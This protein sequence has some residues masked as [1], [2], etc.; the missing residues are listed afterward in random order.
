VLTEKIIIKGLRQNNLKNINIEI[1]KG[2]IVV[3]TGVSGSGKSSIV[4]DTVAAEATRQMNDTYPAFVRSRLPKFASPDCDSIENLSPSVVID[5]TPLGST[6]RSTVGTSSEIYSAL[7]LLFSRIGQPYAGSASF[8]SFNDPNGMCRE[9]SGLGMVTDVDLDAIMNK[10]LSLRSGALLDSTVREG[11]W[12]WKQYISSGLFDADKRLRDYSEKEM[13]LLLHGGVR[14]DGKNLVGLLDIYRKRYLTRDSASINAEKAKRVLKQKLC[15]CCNGKRLNRIALS[16]WINGNSIADL[17]DMELTDLRLEL[18]KINEPCVKELVQTTIRSIDRMIDIG[19]G[20]LSLSRATATLSGGEAQRVKLVRHLGSSL[21]DMLYIFDEPSTGMH[22]RDVYRMNNLLKELRDKGN[23]VL[24]VEHDEDVIAIADEIIDIGPLAGKGGGT[25][26]YQGT[27]EGLERA[28]TLTGRAISSRKAISTVTTRPSRFLSVENAT[29]H[30]LKNASV[31]I[32]LGCICTV[33]GVAGSGKSS[34]MQVFADKYSDRVIKIDQKP[35]FATNRSMPCSYLGFFDEVRKELARENNVDEGMFSFNS[36]GACP[37]C[38]GKGET[39]TELAFM[40]PIVTVCEYC[41][42]QRYSDEALSYKYKGKNIVEIL[43][44]TARE[45]EDFF[46]NKRIKAKIHSMNEVG[47][48]YLTLGQP[49]STLSGGERQR[50]KLSASIG[51]RGSIFLLDEPTTGL[52]PT[53]IDK[54]MSLFST[55]VKKGCSVVL[56]E[57]NLEVMKMSDYIIDVGPDGGKNGGEVVFCGTPLEM[58]AADTITARCLKK[59]NDGEAFTEAELKEMVSVKSNKQEENIMGGY[60]IIPIGRVESDYGV[61]RI[62]L[63][64]KYRDALTEL[65][66]FSH[67]QVLCWFEGCDNESAR[68]HLINIK[69]YTNGPDKVGTFATRS[70]ERPN[71]IALS[72]CEIASVDKENAIINLTYIDAFT[73][74][75]VCDIKPYTPSADK[76]ENAKVPAWCAHWPKSYEESESFD[77]EKEFNF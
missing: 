41:N 73:G 67:I 77:W 2:I 39:V 11:S 31:D 16:C 40:D 26:V 49:M 17:C 22:P 52:H 38:S 42:G 34:L 44:L 32:P 27:Y 71:P 75:P 36:S 29:L 65:Q 7:R 12:Y 47:L 61:F 33:T 58:L 35:I 57:H 14:A 51:K 62:V 43:S 76:V 8:F 25:V 1:P 54:L 10:E 19:L 28:D 18:E 46:D 55:L 24:V 3:F 20:Y 13:N 37:H 69:P 9:C 4:F 30:N 60:K 72:V 48:S 68:N 23:T 74:T 56:I 64:K 50:I 59:S 53:D 21:T 15:P 66:G 70:P 45:A 6:A 63:D 5:Q